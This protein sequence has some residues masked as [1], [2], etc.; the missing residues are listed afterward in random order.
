MHVEML[1]RVLQ[2]A[3]EHLELFQRQQLPVVLQPIVKRAAFVEWHL[4]EG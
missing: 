1:K 2:L 4:D 3:R